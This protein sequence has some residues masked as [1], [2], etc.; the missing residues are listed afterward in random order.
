MEM[1]V[2]SVVV[3]VYPD[4][5]AENGIEGT[6]KADWKGL[7]TEVVV[8]GILRFRKYTNKKPDGSSLYERKEILAPEGCR[9]S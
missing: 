4:Q 5:P 6:K 7:R 9:M 3:A 2:L 1:P 8:P